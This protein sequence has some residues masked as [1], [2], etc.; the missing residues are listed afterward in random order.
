MKGLFE[1]KKISIILCACMCAILLFVGCARANEEDHDNN[2]K[3]KKQREEVITPDEPVRVYF[4][5]ET[6]DIAI[7]NMQKEIKEYSIVTE[8]K[9]ISAEEAWESF[10]QGYFGD[11][12]DSIV[13]FDDNP[14]SNSDNFEIYVSGT[15]KE[16]QAFISELEAM[17]GV[18]KVNKSDSF[19]EQ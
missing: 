18:R 5:E 15:K 1:L 2:H 16:I 11:D 3:T 17:D 14:L 12:A 10:K 6:T 4:E 8:V 9:Y 13:D 19:F 7:Q